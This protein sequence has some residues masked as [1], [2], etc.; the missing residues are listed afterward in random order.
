MIFAIFLGF[1]IS[2]IT[3]LCGRNCS[4]V[5]TYIFIHMHTSSCL[6][7]SEDD[8]HMMLPDVWLAS[9]VIPL[10]EAKSRYD[11][12]NYRPVRLTSVCCKTMERVLASK[13]IYYLETNGLLSG[14][15]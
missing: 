8:T 5:L 2:K 4:A 9:V 12:S 6:L 14:L 3:T 7:E 15:F 10:F 11:P 1:I 13:L